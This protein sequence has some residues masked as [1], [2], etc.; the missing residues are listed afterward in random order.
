MKTALLFTASGPIVILTS[1]SSIVDPALL[2]RL[3]GKG[4]EKFLAYE[5][6]VSLAEERYGGHFRTVLH[7]L[8]ESDDL[9]VVDYNGHR[10]LAL[11]RF[12]EL[13]GPVVH[14]PS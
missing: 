3:A 2:D 10:A 13:Q 14:E 8:H 11:F 7:D 1:Y 6:P 12:D 5:V 4:I 9:R